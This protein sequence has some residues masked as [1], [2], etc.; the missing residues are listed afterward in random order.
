MKFT[1]PTPEEFEL[2]QAMRAY[3]EAAEFQNFV[4]GTGLVLYAIG[5]PL[6][7]LGSD[8]VERI[9][10]A[11]L[12]AGLIAFFI[13]FLLNFSTHKKRIEAK[14]LLEPY[15]KKKSAPLFNEIKEKFRDDPNTEFVH[16]D[17]GSVT[18]IRKNITKES[19]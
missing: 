16:N 7:I 19:N 9:G 10:I 4:F 11:L 2:D 6:F 8:W 17:D 18:V 3:Q 12:V 1:T 15:L 14:E 13:N 5:F